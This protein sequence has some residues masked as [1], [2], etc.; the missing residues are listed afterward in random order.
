MQNRFILLGL[1]VLGGLALAG[2]I[3][4]LVI[5]P[6]KINPQTTIPSPAQSA[7]DPTHKDLEI[8]ESTTTYKVSVK[9]P[10][11]S[12]LKNREV[13]ASVNNFIQQEMER[14]V[15]EFKK[16][17]SE[18]ALEGFEHASTFDS[19]YE[20]VNQTRDL[21]SLNFSSYSYISGSAH[22]LGVISSFNYNLKENKP[23][24]LADL[25]RKDSNYLSFLSEKSRTI[26]KDKMQEYYVEEFVMSGTEP[27]P[28]N[29]VVYNF[30]KDRLTLIFNV[31]QVAPYVAG[32][33]S[34][35]IPYEE[36]ADIVNPEIVKMAAGGG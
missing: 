18:M 5:A 20:I 13:D 6:P 26:L 36:M 19:G 12:D 32:P 30:G 31:Y 35:D 9:Y 27:N 11:F 1:I 4:V 23:I 33:Q 29:Y 10:V 3:W 25:F 34:L 21:L 16:Q 17:V 2:L 22:G 8:K 7:P 14:Q 28:E 15:G 24:I